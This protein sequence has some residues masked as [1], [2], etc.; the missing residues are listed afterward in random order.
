[1]TTPSQSAVEA[2]S[3]PHTYVEHQ[4]YVDGQDEAL[5]IPPEQDP[6]DHLKYDREYEQDEDYDDLFDPSGEDVSDSE[7]Q[8]SNPGDYTKAYNRQRRL[9]DSSIPEPHRPKTNPQ[10]NTKAAVDDQVRSLSK[11]R[12]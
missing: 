5:R 11:T 2:L 6:V 4:G 7:L 3:P 12:G 8:V 10:L 9:N 1:M